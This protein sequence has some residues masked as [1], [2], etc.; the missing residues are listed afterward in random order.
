MR[1]N[2][3]GGDIEVASECEGGAVHLPCMAIGKDKAA[4][5]LLRRGCSYCE[6]CVYWGGVSC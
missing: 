5:T 3:F 2:S 6:A 1:M 4:A